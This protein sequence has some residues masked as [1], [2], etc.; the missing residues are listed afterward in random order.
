MSAAAGSDADEIDIL[1]LIVV[2]QAFPARP[3]SLPDVRAF[4]RGNLTTTPISEDDIRALCDRVAE[5]LLDTAG[6]S[7]SLQ[8]SLRIFPD[9]AEVDVL[10]AAGSSPAV[11][12]TVAG[13]GGRIT[14]PA[15]RSVSR[16]P[17][18]V[19]ITEEPALSFAAWLAAGLRREGLSM[20]AAA[21]RLNVSTKTIGRWVSGATE[22]RLRDLY[23]IREIFG[24]PPL[25]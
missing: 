12:E 2:A 3:S 14:A 21:R 7:S 11:Q 10:G 20:E 8:V 23:R 22:P 16:E 18:S 5:V 6:V 15:A 4:L 13:R 17:V 1:P 9:G 19:A 25:L 24:E